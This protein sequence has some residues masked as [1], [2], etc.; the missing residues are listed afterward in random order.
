M[1]NLS[2]SDGGARTPRPIHYR[3][4]SGVPSHARAQLILAAGL[5][6]SDLNATP[7][8][9]VAIDGADEVDR[10]LACIKGGG[11][12]Q[13]QEKLVAAAAA[14]FVVVADYRKQA[15]GGLGTTWRKGVPVEVLPIAYVCVAAALEALGGVPTLRMAVAKAGPV[16]TDNGGFV[17]DVAFPAPLADPRA[18]HAAIKLLP[19]VI[20]T[21]IFAG[22]AARAYFGQADG[23]VIVWDAPEQDD[24][25]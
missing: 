11:A 8:L 16:V 21:G 17:L 22:M 14:T 20:E 5:P 10:G 2:R 25:K 1:R 7:R 13:T 24:T 23:S 19:G 15:P 4:P 18:L 12:C 9:D 3:P 6:L